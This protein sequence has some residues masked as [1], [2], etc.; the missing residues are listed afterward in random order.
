MSGQR[1]KRKSDLNRIRPS[2]VYSVKR[3]AETLERREETVRRWIKDGM[4]T[5][6]FEC[7]YMI[8]GQEA[9][10]WLNQKWRQRKKPCALDQLYCLPCHSRKHPAQDSVAIIETPDGGLRLEAKCPACGASIYMA[11]KMADKAEITR[12]MSRFMGNVRHLSG[13][14]HPPLNRTFEQD[15]SPEFKSSPRGRS[16]V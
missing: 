10:H 3:L 6:G 14:S 16:N 7:P 13:Y 15:T 12:L 1:N 11:R 8:D 5:I 9:K 4:P 2:H